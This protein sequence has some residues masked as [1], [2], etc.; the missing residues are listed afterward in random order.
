MTNQNEN[1]VSLEDLIKNGNQHEEREMSTYT[2]EYNQPQLTREGYMRNHPTFRERF[3]PNFARRISGEGMP[4]WNNQM[5]SP[6]PNPNPP[7]GLKEI[8]PGK[9]THNVTILGEIISCNMY[10]TFSVELSNTITML[11]SLTKVK[12]GNMRIR[13]SQ[14]L[15]IYVDEEASVIL[16]INSDSTNIHLGFLDESGNDYSVSYADLTNL[17]EYLQLIQQSIKEEEFVEE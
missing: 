13:L 12:Y 15:F 5:S 9:I 3:Q 7:E 6:F 16:S 14:E 10:D 8:K 4:P 11:D 2:N 17:V 1:M